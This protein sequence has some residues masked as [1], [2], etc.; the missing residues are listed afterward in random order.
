VPTQQVIREHMQKKG[1]DY[2]LTTEGKHPVKA[3]QDRK[4][5]SDDVARS[6]S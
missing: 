3:L 4:S 5:L 1:Q 6:R 2:R